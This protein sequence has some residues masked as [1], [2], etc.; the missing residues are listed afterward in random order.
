MKDKEAN[1]CLP[2]KL[3]MLSPRNRA[4]ASCD[5]VNVSPCGQSTDYPEAY[6]RMKNQTESQRNTVGCRGD[7]L[8]QGWIVNIHQVT[9][10]C[11]ITHNTSYFICV[12]FFYTR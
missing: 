7:Y 11:W 4:P 9:E 3:K 1:R 8:E 6:L 10:Y 5:T 12:S 2:I